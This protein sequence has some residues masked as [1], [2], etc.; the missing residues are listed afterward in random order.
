MSYGRKDYF[1]GVAPEK[2]VFGELQNNWSRLSANTVTPDDVISIVTYIVPAGKILQLTGILMCASLPGLQFLQL[3]I[4]A[5]IKAE[6]WFDTNIDIPFGVGGELVVDPG[7]TFYVFATNKD[8]V[9]VRFTGFST[10]FL[11]QTIV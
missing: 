5:T 1:W 6:I 9:D 10:G 8:E 2:S 4:D 3:K 11:Q 7:E